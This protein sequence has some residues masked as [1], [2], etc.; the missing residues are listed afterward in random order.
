MRG[1]FRFLWVGV[2]VLIPAVPAAAGTQSSIPSQTSD[3]W[4]GYVASGASDAFTSVSANWV[5]PAVS[6]QSKQLSYAAFWDGLDGFGDSTVEQIGTTV[7]CYNGFPQTFAWYD[8]Y[9]QDPY[10]VP[11]NLVIKPGD[12]ISASVTYTPP[13]LGISLFGPG[14]YLLELTDNTTAETFSTTQ[15]ASSTDNRLSAEVVAEAPTASGA[16]AP[17]SDFGTVPFSNATIDNDPLAS[18]PGLERL[19]LDDPAGMTATPSAINQSGE[20]FS[21]VWGMS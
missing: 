17:L 15:T 7:E 5:E 18:T 6:C 2:F 9:P 3:R 4:S 13:F 16:V 19:T 10:E 1:F 12:L 11:T 8:M 14:S 20:G 21:V